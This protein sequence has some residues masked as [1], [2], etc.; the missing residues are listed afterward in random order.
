MRDLSGSKEQACVASPFG[1]SQ[2]A[3]KKTYYQIAFPFMLSVFATGPISYRQNNPECTRMRVNIY[4][5]LYRATQILI[6]MFNRLPERDKSV[7]Y[8]AATT[9]IIFYAR[10]IV[11]LLFRMYFQVP[12]NI[13]SQVNIP[14]QKLFLRLSIN[15]HYDLGFF[16]IVRVLAQ[17][18]RSFYRKFNYYAAKRTDAINIHINNK[19]ILI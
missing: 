16:K 18:S 17:L 12:S 11:I 3:I 15:T 2:N 19:E 10:N 8:I 13:L 14:I 1:Q 5:D 6:C 7:G 4:C 9:S